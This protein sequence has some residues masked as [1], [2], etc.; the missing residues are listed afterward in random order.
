MFLVRARK[1][2][3]C[4][5][6]IALLV[7]T[8]VRALLACTIT[9]QVDACKTRTAPQVRPT[10]CPFRYPPIPCLCPAHMRCTPLRILRPV[11]RIH[12]LTHAFAAGSRPFASTSA[13]ALLRPRLQP[14]LPSCSIPHPPSLLLPDCPAL[15]CQSARLACMAPRTTTL[16]RRPSCCSTSRAQLRPL[17]MISPRRL[18]LHYA[19]AL[20]RAAQAGPAHARPGAHACGPERLFRGHIRCSAHIRVSPRTHVLRRGRALWTSVVSSRATCPA[21]HLPEQ[22]QT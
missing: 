11:P 13:S 14:C 10:C 16:V 8:R 6:A 4:A 17:P 20:S 1:C 7:F 9:L 19:D 22:H 12:A 2:A 21:V 5:L 15:I 18:P 3:P